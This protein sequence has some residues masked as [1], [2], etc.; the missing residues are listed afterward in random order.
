ME[1]LTGNIE[2]PPT[3]SA[4]PPVKGSLW[5]LQGIFFQPKET[6]QEI[7]KK[8]TWLIAAIL[9]VVIGA[10]GAI[11]VMETIGLDN[12]MAQELRARGQELS[13]EQLQMVNSPAAKAVRYAFVIIMNPV[14]LLVTAGVL[15][16]LFMIA[17]SEAKFS[18][19]FSVVVHSFL[20]YTVVSMVIT[21]V[22]VAVAPDPTELDIQN[23]VA[24]NLGV[25][26]SRTEAPVLF[27][28]L[29][30]I[31]LLSF[32]CIFLLSLGMSIVGRKSLA[33]S[34]ALV[35]IPWG[36]WVLVKMGMATVF[37]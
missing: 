28:L 26:V 6:F 14:M 15:M 21:V 5:R 8:P 36:L 17:G 33:T 20:A 23:L 9:L 18:R 1:N 31:D 22:I 30:S 19:I 34:A 35:V 11:W 13:E 12:I 37:S 25:L 29:S 27:A 16:A 10:V 3:T 24:S 7:A 2:Q 32:Y 4:A